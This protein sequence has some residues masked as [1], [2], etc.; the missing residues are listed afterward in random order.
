MD[1][2][3]LLILIIVFGLIAWLISY[4]P[5]PYPFRVAAYVILV[6]ILIL[7]LVGRVNVGV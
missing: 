6:I 4:I 7:V 3:G 1:L 2:V 5:L